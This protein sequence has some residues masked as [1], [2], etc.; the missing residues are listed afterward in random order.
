MSTGV[1]RVGDA[2]GRTTKEAAGL[3]APGR[4]RTWTVVAIAAVALLA[5]ISMVVAVAAGRAEPKLTGT[6]L[7]K[8]PSPGFQ[9]RDS[10]GQG[11]SLS[12]F[13]GKVV[14]LT[15]LYTH[16]PDQCPLT[17][18]ILRHADEAADHP[19]DVV[20]LAVSIDPNGDTPDSIAQF[21]QDHHLD[22]LGDRW[23]Y[24][25]GTPPELQGVWKSYY[26]YAPADPSIAAGT[27]HT[28]GM[29]FIDK[30]GNR[31][32]Y[33]SL[34]VAPEDVARNILLLANR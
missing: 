1:D 17:A 29:Y 22:A 16:C 30:H 7:G 6:A 20:Y 3:R 5:V 24:L 11:Y 10:S 34:P 14:V 15:F 4:R 18:E 13:R 9:L 31:R 28:T 2:G 8:E 26:I 21:T 27:D 12:Q 33:T 32:L 19:K 23:H 25:V